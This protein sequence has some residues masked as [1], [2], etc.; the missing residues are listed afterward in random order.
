MSAVNAPAARP[1]PLVTLKAAGR[2]DIG[3]RRQHNEDVVLVREDL[4]LFVVADG[5]GGHN[6]GEVASALAARSMENYF[7]ATIR[8]THELPE[9]NRF[10][11]PNGA[12]RLS[13]AVHKA[14]RDVVEIARTSPKH[15]GMGT[16]VVATCFSPRS[17][18]MHVAHVG[19][20]RCYRMR[21]GDFELLTQDHSLLT[22]VLEQRPELDDDMLARLPKNIVTRAI[23]LD[24]QLRVSIRSFSVVEGDRYLLCS[25]GLSGP[26]P[27]QEL[28]DVLAKA[29]TPTQIVEQLLTRANAHGGPDNVAA[30]I[31]DCQG[32]HKTALP[33]DS[34]PPP[35]PE[36]LA[37]FDESATS[38]PEL[39]ILGIQDLD[40]AD[41]V[42]ASDDLLK[43][44]E[45]LIGHR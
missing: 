9:F 13:A 36:V 1:Q 22:D 20:S 32:G 35:P 21:D 10:G 14:N 7:G 23:G 30:L 18:L 17:G 31:I 4:G 6:A 24:G 39:L 41:A 27:A 3:K 16:T 42:S 15:R 45:D 28:A 12:R 8:A 43:A 26:V 44:I 2:T 37:M 29:E 25:D 11:V 40:V 38:E 34:V 5:A 33:A 19:D